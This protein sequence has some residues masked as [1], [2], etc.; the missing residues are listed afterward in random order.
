LVG[1]QQ[2]S[3]GWAEE[4]IQISEVN[5]GSAAENWEQIG[6]ALA[7]LAHLGEGADDLAIVEPIVLSVELSLLQEVCF[8]IITKL[9]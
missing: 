2:R 6:G 5:G 7:V 8:F 3:I 4:R 1:L 9:V